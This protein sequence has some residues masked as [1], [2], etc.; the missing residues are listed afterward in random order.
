[1]NELRKGINLI[2]EPFLA[3]PAFARTV[4]LLCAY[5]AKDGCFGFVLNKMA[6][7]SLAKLKVGLDEFNW[8]VFAGGPVQKDSLHYLH[9]Y[10]EFFPDAVEVLDGLY[11]GGD[12]GLLASLMNEGKIREDKIKFFLGYS[13]WD[14]LQLEGEMEEHSWITSE[15]SIDLS[16]KTKSSDIWR[17]SLYELG[18]KFRAFANFP[19]DPKLN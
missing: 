19:T 3:D 2:A 15:G 7:T 8:K 17:K 18:G 16:L 14:A 11:W 1:M 4:V 12:F 6:N 9:Q 13:G 10:P 5:E